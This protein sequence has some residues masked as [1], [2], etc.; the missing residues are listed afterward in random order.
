VFGGAYGVMEWMGAWLPHLSL[1]IAGDAIGMGLLFG[2]FMGGHYRYG[3][4]RFRIPLWTDFR[5]TDEDAF[6]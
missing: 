5:P 6:A 1:G 2:L 4:R 3:A